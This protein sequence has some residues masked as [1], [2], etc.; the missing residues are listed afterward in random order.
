MM[1]MMT[2]DPLAELAKKVDRL[3]IVDECIHALK[4]IEMYTFNF[5]RFRMLSEWSLYHPRATSVT[6]RSLHLDAF[7]TAQRLAWS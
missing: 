4:V 7:L 2:V 6:E 3:L 1:M 5:M